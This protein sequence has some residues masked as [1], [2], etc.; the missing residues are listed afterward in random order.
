[1]NLHNAMLEKWTTAMHKCTNFG[2]SGF[3]NICGSGIYASSHFEIGSVVGLEI[4]NELL[5][6]VLLKMI[7]A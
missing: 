6:N 3:A 7:F 2:G 1:M 4:Q 5:L